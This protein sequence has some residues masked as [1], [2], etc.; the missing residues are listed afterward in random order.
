MIPKSFN[1]IWESQSSDIPK[2]FI[3]TIY[4]NLYDLNIF[5]DQNIKI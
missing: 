3:L 5:L 1:F 2:K 4:I